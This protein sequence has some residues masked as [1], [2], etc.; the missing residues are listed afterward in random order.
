[1]VVFGTIYGII[2]LS[3]AYY[4]ELI[5]Y[6]GMTVPMAVISLVS[7]M[8]NPYKGKKSEVRINRIKGS[9]LVFLFALSCVVS[10]AFYFILK[11]FGT[12]SLLT[13]T[14]SVT[15]SFFAV[16]L[17]FRRSPLFALAYA[18]NDVVLIVLWAFASHDDLS[19][20][21]VIV[22]FATFLVNDLYSFFSWLKRQKA[23]KE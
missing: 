20:I 1:M 21:S 15:T 2:S 8:R 4:G 22:C 6:V 10:V 23:Q 18:A 7:W 19:C 13:S 9:E 3:H 14:L 12:A 5:T 16:C 17:T 11:V